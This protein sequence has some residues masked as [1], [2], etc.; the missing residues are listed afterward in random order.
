MT[1]TAA[2]PRRTT[3]RGPGGAPGITRAGWLLGAGVIAQVTY[4]L[5]GGAVRDWVSVAAVLLLA[6][7]PRCVV[8]A[9]D[10]WVAADRGVGAVVV[11]GV[12]PGWQ[13]GGAV[14]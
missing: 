2:L 7:V 13:G 11:V 3:R 5:S 9:A 12:Q 14:G 1:P 10:G 4:P 6:V 8:D